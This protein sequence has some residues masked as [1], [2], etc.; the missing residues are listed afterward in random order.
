MCARVAEGDD[1]GGRDESEMYIIQESRK[2]NMG[3]YSCVA[4]AEDGFTIVVREI[5]N[6]NESLSFTNSLFSPPP[7][8]PQPI[9]LPAC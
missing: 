1:D 6:Y 2:D 3:L 9:H 7:P 4:S 5:G 8:P